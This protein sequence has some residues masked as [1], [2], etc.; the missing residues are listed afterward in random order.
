MG[1]KG[2]SHLQES[3]ASSCIVVALEDKWNHFEHP[4][5]SFFFPSLCILIIMPHSMEYPFGHWDQLSQLDLLTTFC[6]PVAYLLVGWFEKQ[7]RPSIHAITAPIKASMCYQHCFQHK[8]ELHT[9]KKIKSIPVKPRTGYFLPLMDYKS[10]DQTF[11][12]SVQVRSNL[13]SRVTKYRRS[14]FF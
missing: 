12:K 3:K 9:V 10:W 11:A 2:C 4:P 5:S 6:A 13:K 14:P 7:N 1:R 8:A